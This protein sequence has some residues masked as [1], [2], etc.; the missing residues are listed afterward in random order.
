MNIC[1]FFSHDH[2]EIQNE[3]TMTQKKLKGFLPFFETTA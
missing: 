2:Y 3:I 1:N